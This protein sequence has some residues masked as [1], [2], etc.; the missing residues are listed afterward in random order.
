M[1]QP[2]TT[3]ELHPLRRVGAPLLFVT[4]GYFVDVFDL[5]LFAVVRV[6]SVRDLGR[7]ATRSRWAHCCRTRNCWAS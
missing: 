2:V 1:T 5:L 3:S 6:P 4:L 7:G